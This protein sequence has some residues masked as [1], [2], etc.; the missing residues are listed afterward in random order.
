MDM[1]TTMSAARRSFL[2]GSGGMALAAAVPVAAF[3]AA[4][5]KAR[6]AWQS[7]AQTASYLYA[8]SSGALK[9]AGLDVE[10]LK[11]SAGPPIFAALRSDSVDISFMAETPASILLAQGIPAKVF[12]FSADYG[13]AMG[14]VT[15]KGSGIDSAAALRGKKIAVVRGSAAHYTLGAILKQHGMSFG[16]V[17]LMS[18]DVTNLIPAFQNRDVD[19]ALYWEPWMSRLVQAGGTVLMTNWQAR[20]PS[21]TMWVARTKWLEQNPDAA[22]AFVKALDSVVRVIRTTPDKVA[23]TISTELGLE[24]KLLVD[25]LAKGN[26]F[27][28]AREYMS[29]DYTYSLAPEAVAQGRGLAGVLRDVATFMKDNGVVDKVPDVTQAFYPDAALRYVKATA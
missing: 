11:F 7:S 1:H 10:H 6:V 24:P 8:H 4:P 22:L 13:G 2:R 23:E 28:T 21:A 14:L 26:K 25:V 27:P 5:V 20:Q 29:A 12:A 19:A 15:A 18:L 16:D 3:G 17:Q 9:N